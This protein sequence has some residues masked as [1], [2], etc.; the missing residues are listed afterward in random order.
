MTVFEIE[1]W[2]EHLR[3]GRTQRCRY[4]E[5]TSEGETH[6]THILR[7]DNSTHLQ[8]GELLASAT[9]HGNNL[10]SVMHHFLLRLF[11]PSLKYQQVRK[12][13]KFHVIQNGC[14]PSE[15][16]FWPQRTSVAF[17]FTET[18]LCFTPFFPSCDF[19]DSL[20]CSAASYTSS[21]ESL[22]F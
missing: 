20:S 15:D 14:S 19:T 1:I 13:F 8:K 5:H 11:I 17:H 22:Q 3:F 2:C 16:S 18:A 12:R 21:R 9:K 7:R 6:F 10:V 4:T